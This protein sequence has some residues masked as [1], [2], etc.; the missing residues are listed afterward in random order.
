M[1]RLALALGSTLLTLGALEGAGRLL[2][3]P[4]ERP[5]FMQP[6]PELGWSLRP[7]SRMHLGVTVR[8]NGLGLRGPA[9]TGGPALAAFGDSSVFGHGV[10]DHEGFVGRLREALDVEVLNGGVP[11]YQCSQ[12][13]GAHDR[14]AEHAS[15]ELAVLYVMHS[16]GFQFHER[17]LAWS[18]AMPDGLR[19]TG[20][21]RL[22]SW[23]TSMKLARTGAR[24]TSVGDYRA[25]L[26]D[27]VQAV[28]ALLVIPMARVDVEPGHRT[29]YLEPYREAMRQVAEETGTPLADTAAAAREVG[30]ERLLMDEVHPSAEGHALVAEVVLAAVAEHGLLTDE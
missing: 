14:L 6:D 2:P 8:T 16:D 23:G 25:C 18:S 13:R 12:A 10:Q 28:P 5:P 21:G 4:P 15:V 30:S 24:R 26:T 9:P 11:G 7:D 19:A 17:D 29:A 22:L 1:R 27:F 20:L 3:V